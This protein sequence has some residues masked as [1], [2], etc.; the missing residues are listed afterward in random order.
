MYENR[1]N[2]CMLSWNSNFQWHCV[3]RKPVY[4]AL[5]LMRLLNLKAKS[6]MLCFL[7]V[8][9]R[10]KEMLRNNLGKIMYVICVERHLTDLQN[11]K[12]I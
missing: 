8:F 7:Q 2:N 5:K 3:V 1:Y 4:N 6:N 12:H 9:T 11:W 10:A